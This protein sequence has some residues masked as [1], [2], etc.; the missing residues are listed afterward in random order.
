MNFLEEINHIHIHFY[1]STVFHIVF[2]STEFHSHEQFSF[3][4]YK[5]KAQ[6]LL[7]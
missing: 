3:E 2:I 7:C 6:K 5:K 4:F 1:S